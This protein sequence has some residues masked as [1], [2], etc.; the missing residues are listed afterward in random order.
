[1]FEK[2]FKEID[3]IL[4]FEVSDEILMDRLKVRGLTS[5]REDDNEEAIANRINQYH[6]KTQP[7]LDFYNHFGKVKTIDGSLSVD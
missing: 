3:Y 5:G 2:K 1:M 4:N 6:S 7:V